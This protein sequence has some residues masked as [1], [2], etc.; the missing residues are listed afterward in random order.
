L[1]ING[2]AISEIQLK[3]KNFRKSQGVL[4]PYFYKISEFVLKMQKCVPNGVENKQ[5]MVVI[6]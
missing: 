2:L 4:T 1:R 6:G 3:D 5:V